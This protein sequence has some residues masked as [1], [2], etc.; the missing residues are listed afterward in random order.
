MA[1]DLFFIA[2]DT[3]LVT[4]GH[5]EMGNKLPFKVLTLLPASDPQVVLTL[6]ALNIVSAGRYL[7]PYLCNYNN[8]VTLSLEIGT[9]RNRGGCGS[10]PL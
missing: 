8:L 6:T 5:H 4:Y 10:T 1:N 3:A 7:Y 9:R 2:S